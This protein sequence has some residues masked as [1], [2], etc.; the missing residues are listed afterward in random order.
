MYYLGKG[1]AFIDEVQTTVSHV[2]IHQNHATADG[3][4]DLRLKKFRS[5]SW[6]AQMLIY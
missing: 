1:G 5:A 3:S 2:D 6:N 4:C